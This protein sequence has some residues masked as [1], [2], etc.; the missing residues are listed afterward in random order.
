MDL[1]EVEV[2]GSLIDGSKYEGI[3]FGKFKQLTVYK[4]I[5]LFGK[6]S[7]NVIVH[8][9]ICCKDPE[10][11]GEGY[12]KTTIKE[13]YKDGEPCGCSKF[14]HRSEKQRLVEAKRCCEYNGY[15]FHGFITEY[16]DYHTRCLVEC[17]IHGTWDQRLES[18]LNKRMC[19]VCAKMR[20]HDTIRLKKEQVFE[21]V[22]AT[23]MFP[24]GTTIE[25]SDRLDHRGSP[26]YWDVYCPTC[27]A[28]NS[29]KQGAL[30]LGHRPCDCLYKDQVFA[31]IQMFK[32]DDIVIAIK[33]GITNNVPRRAIGIKKY[34]VYDMIT[35]GAWK[36]ET[37]EMCRRA[38][39]EC[40][41]SVER[42]ALQKFELKQGYTETT[43]AYNLDKII[44][45]YE[46]Y[47]GVKVE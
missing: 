24:E 47:G 20:T 42:P 27:A 23:G 38:E 37:S 22:M 4:Q 3:L 41:K 44:G 34:S 35:F 7:N 40:G 46:S 9:S 39:H 15:M 31:Y 28:T 2:L 36:F 43:W 18:V 14:A 11:Y 1:S 33:Y 17:P 26:A 45:I 32:S 29:A 21:K 16:D 8:C 25:K 19:P 10:M 5:K 6:N 13:I 12:F 30:Y